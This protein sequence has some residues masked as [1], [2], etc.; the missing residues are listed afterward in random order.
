VAEEEVILIKFLENESILYQTTKT[1]SK[2]NNEYRSK[3]RYLRSILKLA[4]KAFWWR[5]IAKEHITKKIS[6]DK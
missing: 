5:S 2:K 6:K 4:S 1:A 3:S